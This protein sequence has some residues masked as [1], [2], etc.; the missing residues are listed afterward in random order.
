MVERSSNWGKE[1]ENKNI[2]EKIF[3]PI[4]NIIVAWFDNLKGKGKKGK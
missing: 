2:L 4:V 1:G 3:A